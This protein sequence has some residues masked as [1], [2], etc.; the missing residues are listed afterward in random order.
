LLPATLELLRGLT[1][2]KLPCQVVAWN[3]AEGRVDLQVG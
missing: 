1:M 2:R 3:P